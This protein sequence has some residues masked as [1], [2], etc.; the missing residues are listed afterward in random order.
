M[1]I[2]AVVARVLVCGADPREA[3]IWESP[4]CAMNRYLRRHNLGG[5]TMRRIALVLGS[6]AVA[7]GIHIA[8]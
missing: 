8:V 6:V 2:L 4:N 3:M 5:K 7:L 1:A